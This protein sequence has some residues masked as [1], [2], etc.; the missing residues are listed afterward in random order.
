[1]NCLVYEHRVTNPLLGLPVP[2]YIVVARV[3][4]VTR[5][6][7]TRAT[8]QIGLADEGRDP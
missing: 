5:D 8:L 6:Q 1:M 7:Q 2:P 4:T 3:T